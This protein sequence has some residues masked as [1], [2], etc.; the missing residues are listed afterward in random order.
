MLE[1]A[2]SV[3]GSA[4]AAEISFDVVLLHRRATLQQRSYLQCARVSVSVS[5]RHRI[6][7]PLAR[8]CSL[9]TVTLA[10]LRRARVY[11]STSAHSS[12]RAQQQG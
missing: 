10:P 9:H 5:A 12:S 4:P 6:M 1:R 7:L 3:G 11:I 8:A 2:S